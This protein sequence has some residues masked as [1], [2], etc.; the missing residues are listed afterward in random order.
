MAT[1]KRLYKP[2]TGPRDE[3]FSKTFDSLYIPTMDELHDALHTHAVHESIV[4]QILRGD[5]IYYG[6][7]IDHD[8]DNY[9]PSLTYGTKKNINFDNDGYPV[10][11][12]YT[13]IERQQELLRARRE[14][15]KLT[16]EWKEER[17]RK[18]ME[19]KEEKN[20]IRT[21]NRLVKLTA[22]F[23]HISELDAYKLLK[24]IGGI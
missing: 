14:R 8:V 13:K 24:K 6:Y 23:R 9:I 10:E 16:L 11:D 18:R 15:K 20:R 5:G 21:S 17:W 7:E 3:R 22:K 2:L 19:R 1:R 4:K 12:G